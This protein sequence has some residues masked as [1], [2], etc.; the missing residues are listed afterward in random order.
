MSLLTRGSEDHTT[1]APLPRGRVPRGKVAS[2]S[3]LRRGRPADPR[4]KPLSKEYGLEVS[5]SSREFRGKALP[6]EK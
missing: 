3:C 2:P 6:P 1:R 5:G 4:G